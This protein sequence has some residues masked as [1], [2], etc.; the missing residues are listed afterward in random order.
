MRQELAA[1]RAEL[2]QLKADPAAQRAAEDLQAATAAALVDAQ[3]RIDYTAQNLSAG[4]DG[5]FFLESPDGGFRL[6][7]AGHM[8]FRYVS[9]N[10]SNTGGDDSLD[11]F[12]LR[13]TKLNFSGHVTRN[14]KFTYSLTLAGEDDFDDGQFEIEAFVLGYQLSDNWKAQL[15]QMK[16][17]FA[18]EELI[19]SKRQLATDRSVATEYF[20]LDYGQGVLLKYT[21]IDGVV[22]QG[23]LSDGADTENQDFDSANADIADA[24]LTLRGDLVVFGNAKAGK[25]VAAWSGGQDTLLLGA[26]AHYQLANSGNSTSD[27]YFTWTVDALYKTGPLSIIGA[28][29]GLHTQGDNGRGDFDDY[30]MMVGAGYNLDDHWQPFVQYSHVNLDAIKEINAVALGVNYFIDKHNAKFT[31]DVVYFFNPLTT[32]ARTVNNPGTGQGLLPDAAGEDGQFV[33]RAQFQMLF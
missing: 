10:R 7:V 31:T 17:P 3:A 6:N 14:Q 1:M 32:T 26:A 33:F 25:D 9:N 29:Y 11:G 30:A 5:K 22:L 4:H 21:G 19:S 18:R 23:M 20:T 15:G 2:N 8:Q 28:V 12:T 16:L 13:R 27:D 24:A